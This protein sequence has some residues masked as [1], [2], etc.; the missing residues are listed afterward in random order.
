MLKVRRHSGAEPPS[1]VPSARS[2]SSPPPS[3]GRL[4]HGLRTPIVFNILKNHIKTYFQND[5]K[6][7][8]GRCR[9]NSHPRFHTNLGLWQLASS[10]R[11]RR[12]KWRK[13][14]KV[15]TCNDAGGVGGQRRSGTHAPVRPSSH[16][17][18][19]STK[20]SVYRHELFSQLSSQPSFQQSS[21]TSLVT[22]LNSR[23]FETPTAFLR[24]FPNF[25]S[26]LFHA[27]R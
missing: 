2:S 5:L 21:I 27:Y 11:S 23:I 25:G 1:A 16:S 24:Y 7:F 17:T 12:R 18:R 20:Q 26:N 9:A 19:N 10:R 13:E 14:A 4:E 3:P 8:S 22:N 6:S 15:N